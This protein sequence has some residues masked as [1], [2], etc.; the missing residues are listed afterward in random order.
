DLHSNEVYEIHNTYPEINIEESAK[1]LHGKMETLLKPFEWKI[2]KMLYIDHLSED[3]AAQRMGYKTSEKGR[4]P[5][6]KQIKNIKKT[7][8]FKAK[9]LLNSTDIDLV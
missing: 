6:Y 7:I 8:L 4:Q 1:V 2:Y 9:K 3:K 5:G